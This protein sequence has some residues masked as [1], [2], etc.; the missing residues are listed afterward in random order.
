MSR[1]GRKEIPIPEK[2]KVNISDYLVE[3]DGPKGKLKQT[4]FAGI[5]IKNEDNILKVARQ[6]DAP[7]YRAKHGLM[8]ALLANMVKGV[9]E[10]FSKELDIQG[11]GYRAELKGKEL[12]LNL[13]FSHIVPFQIPEGIDISVDKQTHLVV[14]GYDKVLVGQVAADIRKIR[15]PEPYKGKGVRY[16]NEVIIRKAGKSA[17]GK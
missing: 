9:S 12:H 4:I 3:V 7:N 16:S 14:S 17:G 13:G 6:S 1:T 15:P 2:V 10:G 11:V 8:R 5:S